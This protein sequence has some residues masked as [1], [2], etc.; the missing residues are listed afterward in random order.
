MALQALQAGY[1]WWPQCTAGGDLAGICL[2]CL[3]CA[4]KHLLVAVKLGATHPLYPTR[5][6]AYAFYNAL[7]EHVRE[8]VRGCL[9]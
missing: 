3:P 8:K 5:V 2:N 6:P 7:Q 9:G 1:L 4:G